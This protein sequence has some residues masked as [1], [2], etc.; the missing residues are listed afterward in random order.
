M[1]ARFFTVVISISVAG[2]LSIALW[3]QAFG[4]E[5]VTGIAQLVSLR[6]VALIA[7]VVAAAVLLLVA[8]LGRAVRRVAA[9]AAVLL[10]VFAVASGAILYQR[11]LGNDSFASSTD[12]D[13]TVLSWN[14]LGNATGAEAIAQAAVNVGAN[15][16]ALPETTDVAATEVAELMRAAGS[17]MWV[18]SVHFDLVAD[19]RSTSIMI[20]PSLGDYEVSTDVGNTEVLPTVIAT[21]VGHDGP[22][23]VAV[24]A[25]SPI[26]GE[27]DNW[28]S[29]LAWLSTLC[30][31]DNVILAGDFNAT[32]DH[33][34]NL[35][36]DDQ[37]MAATPEQ[38]R[39]DLGRC[40]DAARLTGNAGVGTWHTSIHALAGSP[41]DH[42]M[43]TPEWR[44]TGMS[45][46][47][48]FDESGSDHR[49]IVAQ[50]SRSEQ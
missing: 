10:V 20:S 21:P 50:L 1:L 8:L 23:I 49:P 30:E 29:D 19:A 32:L 28:R 12:G 39:P 33:F 43:V 41:I 25:V 17:P 48:D 3:P 34:S 22:T 31:G 2:V 38:I 27:M 24:H 36:S 13:I 11:G 4:L 35:R 42:V 14:T 44:V 6:A 45:V 18:H 37:V 15:V 5:Q 46:L 47:T 26:E 7:A 9:S 40:S 16:V